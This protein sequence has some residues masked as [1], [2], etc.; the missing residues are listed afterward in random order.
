MEKRREY[1]FV[2][3]RGVSDILDFIRGFLLIYILGGAF[4]SEIFGTWGLIEQIYSVAVILTG[5]GLSQ[6][7]IRFL[8]GSHKSAYVCRLFILSSTLIVALGLLLTFVMRFLDPMIAEKVIKTPVALECLRAALPLILLNALE[9][10]LDGS[11]RARLRIDLHSFVRMVYTM[12]ILGVYF[13]ASKAGFDLA[14]IIKFTLAVKAAYVVLLYLLFALL[15]FG[16]KDDS[17]QVEGDDEFALPKDGPALPAL[18]GMIIFG[19]PLM[20]FGLSTWLF[21]TGGKVILGF[22]TG[23]GEVGR[24]DASLK[25]A[26]LIQYLGLPIA[27]TLL[28]V[29]AEAVSKKDKE[30]VVTICRRFA[31]LYFFLALPLFMGLLATHD[32]ILDAITRREEFN[33]SYAF[34]L[35][36]LLAALIS[37][38]NAFYHNVIF[39]KGH[40]RFLFFANFTSALFCLVINTLFTKSLGMWCTA[41]ASLL[42]Y[43]LLL[44][45][46]AWKVKSYGFSPLR[47]LDLGFAAKC[48]AFSVVMFAAVMLGMRYLTF[49]S[50]I[51]LPLL[52]I[53]GAAVYFILAFAAKKFSLKALLE[54]LVG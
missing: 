16:R 8:G 42:S 10:L 12:A 14:K 9:L 18:K 11:Y 6:S 36:P 22:Q 30:T 4:G 7:V 24:Y 43:I 13:Y 41:L 37:Q 28:P 15:E 25:I 31:R 2:L 53:I 48:A 54:E 3:V 21:G 38:V 44:V 33:V 26:M 23:A 20:M 46:C 34:F 27:Y 29:L 1:F 49:G 5:L 32:V 51:K 45:L 40:S 19:A 47:F 35:L 39:L 52:G 50:L 17:V